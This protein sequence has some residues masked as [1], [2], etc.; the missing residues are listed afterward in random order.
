MYVK[1]LIQPGPENGLGFCWSWGG[2][3]EKTRQSVGV[4]V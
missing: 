2:F 3:T 4:V 1:V